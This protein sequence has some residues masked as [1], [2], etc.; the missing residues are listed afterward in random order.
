MDDDDV[1]GSGYASFMV[2]SLNEPLFS[3][4]ARI[5]FFNISEHADGERRG[6][7]PIRMYL[8]TRLAKTLRVVP[9][10]PI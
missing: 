9:S 4:R 10:D 6:P 3:G 7:A 8:K 5:F 2:R 1:Y